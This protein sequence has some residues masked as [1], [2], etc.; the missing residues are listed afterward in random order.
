MRET[1]I[2]GI[3]ILY[4]L[5]TIPIFFRDVLQVNKHSKNV[6]TGI[7]LNVISGFAFLVLNFIFDDKDLYLGLV[8]GSILIVMLLILYKFTLRNELK[9][10]NFKDKSIESIIEVYLKKL[11][12]VSMIFIITAI[13]MLL[14]I[15]INI[16]KFSTEEVYFLTIFELL[17]IL[18]SIIWFI[19]SKSFI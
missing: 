17:L 18:N 10:F 5:I 8:I 14:L 16:L 9:D 11:R 19:C 3:S 15:I 4:V 2:I 12:I 1:I 7:L 6:N 13:G